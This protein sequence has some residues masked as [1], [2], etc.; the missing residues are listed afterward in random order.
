MKKLL[1]SSLLFLSCLVTHPA[2]AQAVVRLLPGDC[3]D[4]PFIG[5]D[6]TT[7][8][9]TLDYIAAAKKRIAAGQTHINNLTR[10][11]A[12]AS[13][14]NHALQTELGR[15]RTE[16]EASQKTIA[17]LGA[18]AQKLGALP[19]QPPLLADPRTYRVGGLA[20]V[21]GIVA[22]VFFIH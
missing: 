22:G 7:W 9:R 4:R 8:H 12:T 18:Q 19:I 13:A 15:C 21:V 14:G 6:T 1:L 3:I 20:L 11:L 17:E 10:E 16:G 2:T 5:V